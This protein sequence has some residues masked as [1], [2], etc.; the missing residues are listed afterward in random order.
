[1]K[2]KL[3]SIVSMYK[4]PVMG[5]VHPSKRVMALAIDHSTIKDKIKFGLAREITKTQ[6]DV[7]IPGYTDESKLIL[8]K[9]N[10][11]LKWEKVEDLKIE[12]IDGVINNIKTK[13]KL[14]G[15]EDP[16]IINYKKIKHVYFTIAFKLSN[17]FYKIYLG[18]AKGKILSQLKTTAPLI[19][20]RKDIS[21]FKEVAISISKN[22]ALTEM[23]IFNKNTGIEGISI[24]SL[25]KID[26]P[27]SNWKFKKIVLDPRKIKYE[28]CNGHLSPCRILDSSID[29]LNIGIVNGR[30]K[31][32]V[33]GKSIRYGK[34]R[35]GLIL[36]N[37]KTGEIPWISREPLFEDPDAE[38]ITF[39]SDFIK[40]NN[41]K[42]ILYCHV[43]DSFVRAYEINLDELKKYVKLNS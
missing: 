3:N 22:M 29:G 40:L 19:G 39:A 16:D 15:L 23:G 20:P 8:V 10:D 2:I 12:G 14:I 13:G 32:V 36:F 30:E 26:N 21:G 33:N 9:S 41:K 31:S 5:K 35:P 38:T 7:N 34:F 37:P 43:N 4:E 18:H 1:M 27:E 11:L 17:K 25:L 6:G 42:G 28:W 24:I